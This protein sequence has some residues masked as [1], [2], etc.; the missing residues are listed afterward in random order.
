MAIHTAKKEDG[1]L[2]LEH[3]PAES[4]GRGVKHHPLG[5]RGQAVFIKGIDVSV[6]A[7]KIKDLL[8]NKGICVSEVRRLTKR[9]S[10]KPTEV[11]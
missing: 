10:G 9:H 7:N 4:F 11:V 2:L 5:R 6:G 8:Q 3:L 1:D